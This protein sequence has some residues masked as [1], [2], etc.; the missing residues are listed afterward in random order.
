MKFKKTLTLLILVC[1]YGYVFGQTTQGIVIHNV[2]LPYKS[3]K[4]VENNPQNNQ[5]REI[6]QISDT[7]DIPVLNTDTVRMLQI[8]IGMYKY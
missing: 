2:V 8:A 1:R 6:M 3:E 7:M 4:I 5:M